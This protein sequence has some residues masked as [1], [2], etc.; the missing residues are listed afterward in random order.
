LAKYKVV[1]VGGGFGGTKAALVLSK[2]HHFSVTLIHDHPDFRY[3]PT[4]YETATGGKG[5]VSSIPLTEIFEKLPIDLVED[6]MIDIDRKNQNVKTKHSG[7][8]I[9]MQ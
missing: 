5:S 2:S 8:F 1:I 3:Y 6:K 9:M 7:I 4:L